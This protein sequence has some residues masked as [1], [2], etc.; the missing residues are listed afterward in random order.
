MLHGPWAGAPGPKNMHRITGKNS[1]GASRLLNNLPTIRNQLMQTEN[2]LVLLKDS[3]NGPRTKPE[4]ESRKLKKTEGPTGLPVSP[5]KIIAKKW[6][7]VLLIEPSMLD[8]GLD[9]RFR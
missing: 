6:L 4:P 3:Q 7:S 1:A 8:E 5:K 2:S 9:E